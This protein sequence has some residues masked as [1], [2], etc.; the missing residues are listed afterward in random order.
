M[1]CPSTASR[2]IKLTEYRSLL[3]CGLVC[4]PHAH[5]LVC[6]QPLFLSVNSPLDHSTPSSSS[7]SSSLHSLHVV[8][9]SQYLGRTPTCYHNHQ[10][11]HKE[12]SRPRSQIK[13]QIHKLT[14]PV[15][16]RTS[17]SSL[18]KVLHALFNTIL[19]QTDHTCLIPYGRPAWS[20]H[21]PASLI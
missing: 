6:T 2:H 18:L 17:V 16:I 1:W 3:C 19:R 12:I 8:A 13:C 20:P 21:R 11:M 9:E 7:S 14:P 4:Q 5:W 10:L 15:Q